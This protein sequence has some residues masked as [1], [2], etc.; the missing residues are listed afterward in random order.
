MTIGDWG[1]KRD[2]E[3]ERKISSFY[4][5]GTKKDLFFLIDPTHPA[6]ANHRPRETVSVDFRS[7]CVLGSSR[8]WEKEIKISSFCLQWN[9]TKREAMDLSAKAK[10]DKRRDGGEEKDEKWLFSLR[11]DLEIERLK[12]TGRSHD[13]R[14]ICCC[15][16]RVLPTKESRLQILGLSLEFTFHS[17]RWTIY[18]TG[19]ILLAR[20]RSTS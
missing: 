19:R 11:R 16:N 15:C 7:R 14:P 13:Q 20:L 2:W 18:G 1:G 10:A 12:R 9:E 17:S 3:E 8:D 6:D 4:L 5:H